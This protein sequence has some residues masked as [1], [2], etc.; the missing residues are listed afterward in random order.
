M[1]WE[2]TLPLNGIFSGDVRFLA[3]A[4]N[5]YG[6]L[7]WANNL[8]RFYT[9]G[10]DLAR[11]ATK[12][13]LL[14]PPPSS[15]GQIGNK[16]T[17]SAVLRNAQTD[18]PLVDQMVS[19]GLAQQS[20]VALTDS[21]GRAT[22]EIPILGT[23]GDYI[24]T[25][26]FAGTTTLA[27]STAEAALPFTIIQQQTQTT[28]GLASGPN[29]ARAAAAAPTE[30]PY[31][32]TLLDGAGNP[33]VEQTIFYI[34][35]NL[36]TN[37]VII[38]VV[39]TGLFGEAPLGRVELPPGQYKI[40]ASFKGTA[41]YAPSD[42][43]QIDFLLNNSP[44]AVADTYSVDEDQ[45]LNID[46]PGVQANDSDPDGDALATAATTPPAHGTLT[47]Q[48]NGAFSYTP[49]A[50]FFGND[51]FGYM[52]CDPRE[53]CASAA[54]TL[55][56]KPVNDAPVAQN[57]AAAVNEDGSVNLAVLTNDH[58]AD[59][60]LDP[61]SL[62]ITT[63]PTHGDAVVQNGQIVYT[64]AANYHGSDGL[65]YQVCDAGS[66]CASA[67]VAIT[68]NPINDAPVCTDVVATPLT[69]WTLQ[70]QFI[71]VAVQGVT[72]SD[73]DAI[74]IRYSEI[75]QDE[76][77]GSD[78]HRPDAN[79]RDQCRVAE[80]RAERDSEGDGRVYHLGYVAMD[81]HGGSCTGTVRMPTVPVEQSGVV[82]SIDGG[83]LFDS[84]GEG[85]PAC[86]PLTVPT[87][88]DPEPVVFIP[89]MQGR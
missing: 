18:E 48:T 68:V 19:V 30:P 69:I 57:D 3:Q 37:E 80:V 64:P 50:D 66:L 81:G 51:G 7:S 65:T 1:V 20:R 45:T 22:V 56:V 85:A 38:K 88:K 78:E 83:A 79:L 52:V 32:V 26:W 55:T 36:N 29:A 62:S 67:T 42:S 11:T 24:V 61:G 87:D 77:V 15:S 75:F 17:F 72:D 13:A 21:E 59:S 25:A 58:D 84:R 73:G 27:P 74:T 10:G 82:D 16:A 43:A 54:V 8:G 9:P 35:T 53:F 23:P 4:A 46:A 49:A 76:P 34:L 33:L 89:F 60:N 2:G 31:I 41:S 6:L 40:Q 63:E 14:D 71:T 47:L 70:H 12:L 28:L 44:I 39:I 86:G 5:A